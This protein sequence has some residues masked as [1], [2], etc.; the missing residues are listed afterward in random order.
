MDVTIYNNSIIMK[1]VFCISTGPDGNRVACTLE[2]LETGLYRVKYRPVCV[3][4]HN[5]TITQRKQP[6]TKQPFA[7]QVFDPL[8]VKL[9]DL[10]EAFCHRAATFKGIVSNS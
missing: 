4:T 5:V 10:S 7:V 6:I 1:C 8:Q 9:T 2:K 3:G